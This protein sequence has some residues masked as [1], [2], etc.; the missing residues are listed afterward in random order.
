MKQ[1]RVKL[2]SRVDALKTLMKYLG[3]LTDVI[4]VR[5]IPKTAEEAKVL[6]AK[7]LRRIYG[8]KLPPGMIPPDVLAMLD[9]TN[10]V[11]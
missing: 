5:D 6:L 1:R 11:H 7:E 3:L 4:S 2:Y 9:A 8:D 10:G